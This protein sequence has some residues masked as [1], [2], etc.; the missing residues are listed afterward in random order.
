MNMVTGR[1]VRSPRPDEY[2][3]LVHAGFDFDPVIL[4]IYRSVEEA[5]VARDRHYSNPENSDYPWNGVFFK[6]I[7]VGRRIRY[8]KHV[9][10]GV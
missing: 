5:N 2:I 9:R 1:K 10:N 4:G 6:R 3:A 8:G 7:R